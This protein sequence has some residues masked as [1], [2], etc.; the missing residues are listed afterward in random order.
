[1]SVYLGYAG[2]YLLRNNFKA[3]SDLLVEQHGWSTVQVGTVLS[4]FTISYGVAKFIMGTLADRS[5]LR[6]A[7]S[8]GL[9]ASSMVN[10]VMGS[11]SVLWALFGLMI[12]NGAIQGI[13]SPSALSSVAVWFPNNLRGSRV[14][15]WNTSHNVGGAIA[16]LLTSAALALFGPTNW[17]M[18]FWAPAVIC[19]GFTAVC[20]MLGA[21]RP[22]EEGLPDLR[23][24]YG[25][26]GVP[27]VPPS[28]GV[29]YW[30]VLRREVVGNKL[31]LIVALL[32]ALIYLVRFGILNWIPIFLTDEKGFSLTKANVAFSILEWMAIP[33]SLVYAAAARRWISRMSTLA[34]V[35]MVLLAGV[36]LIYWSTQMVSVV[37]LTAG[38]LGVLGYRPNLIINVLTVNF[39]SG[40]T[41]GAAVGFVGLAGYLLGEL[42]ANLV[43]GYVAE[44]MGWGPCFMLMIG[45]A[46]LC[47]WLFVILSR[48]ERTRVVAAA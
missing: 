33:G 11:T 41:A 17:H 16:P 36:V 47:A 21:N 40:R 48:A 15:V 10:I 44:H 12:V 18:V 26:S 29:R 35:S 19:I 7:F 6:W 23:S 34:A 22:E 8:L 46:L 30:T 25:P 24:M 38:L 14:A 37:M 13:M 5:K 20:F 45:A 39:V 43:I 2:C 31:I 3:A 28:D 42:T 4:A 32:N 9:L 1:M 27:E